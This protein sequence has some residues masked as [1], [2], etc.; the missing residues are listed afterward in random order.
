MAGHQPGYDLIPKNSQRMI[1][2]K[3][4]A[5]L[6]PDVKRVVNRVDD[7]LLFENTEEGIHQLVREIFAEDTRPASGNNPRVMHAIRN[8]VNG[9]QE[10]ELELDVSIASIRIT[11]RNAIIVSPPDR[12]NNLLKA[13]ILYIQAPSFQLPSEPTQREVVTHVIHHAQLSLQSQ[14]DT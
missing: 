10:T 4:A 11:E 9:N 12:F 7:I 1:C 5:N 3:I 2:V 8:A 13:S 6:G 14:P